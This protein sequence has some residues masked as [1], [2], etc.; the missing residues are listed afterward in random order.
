MLHVM[1]VFSLRVN[2]FPES[3]RLVNLPHGVEIRVKVRG[4]EHHVGQTAFFD[5]LKQGFRVLQRPK[6]RRGDLCPLKLAAINQGFPHFAGKAGKT[7][8]FV[9]QTSVDVAKTVKRIGV[10]QQLVRLRSVQPVKEFVEPGSQVDAVFARLPPDE[11][12]KGFRLKDEG[13]LGK[14]AK[15]DPNQQPFLIMPA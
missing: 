1:V 3:A 11:L 10:V 9:E 6:N 5:G 14:K 15:K 7:Q 8:P 12:G 13:V 2:H 4:L